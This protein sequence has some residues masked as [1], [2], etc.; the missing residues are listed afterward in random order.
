MTICD[1]VSGASH[2]R[3]SPRPCAQLGPVVQV[4][5]QSSSPQTERSSRHKPTPKMADPG[6]SRKAAHG[7][8]FETDLFALSLVQLLVLI[9]WPFLSGRL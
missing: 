8:K 1:K 9:E 7:I 5:A 3:G 6:G 2:C 4:M